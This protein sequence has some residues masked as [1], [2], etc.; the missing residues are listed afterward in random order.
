MLKSYL[1]F[2]FAA[3]ACS[4]TGTAAAFQSQPNPTFLHHHHHHYS[5]TQR[6]QQRQHQ[7]SMQLQLFSSLILLADVDPS[8]TMDTMNAL[9]GA[10]TDMS[11]TSTTTFDPSIALAGSLATLAVIGLLTIDLMEKDEK[12]K[13]EEEE[14]SNKNSKENSMTIS[15]TK[16]D[17]TV[18]VLKDE[19]SSEQLQL[20]EEEV[21][22]FDDVTESREALS[23]FD[24]GNRSKLLSALGRLTGLV[25]STRRSLTKEQQLREIAESNLKIVGEELRDVEDKYEL[26]QNELNKTQKE[27]QSTQ[28]NL[29]QTQKQLQTTTQNLNELQEE[30]KS[31]R[32]L[33]L[34]AWRLSKDRVKTRIQKIRRRGGKEKEET[35]KDNENT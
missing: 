30:R 33:S 27:L 9:S 25:R 19:D 1:S 26:G 7:S 17:D 6:Q 10:T 35:N 16:S 34:V 20:E 4:T 28:S 18:V 14:T 29:E 24:Q 15:A 11:T 2:F 31:L 22:T 32:K 23:A 12:G 21:D 13:E 8:V 3:V 5:R